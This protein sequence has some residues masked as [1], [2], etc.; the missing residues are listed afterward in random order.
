MWLSGQAS[1]H[2]KH[3]AS[4]F[5]CQ[6]NLVWHKISTQKRC[7]KKWC[8]R[9]PWRFVGARI[10][11][12]CFFVLL[13]SIF[14]AE[15]VDWTG[16]QPSFSS[17]LGYLWRWHPTQR[18]S[19]CLQRMLRSTRTNR[20]WTVFSASELW[21][22]QVRSCLT[23]YHMAVLVPGSCDLPLAK[24]SWTTICWAS[25]APTKGTRGKQR[26]EYTHR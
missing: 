17:E 18:R 11:R 26:F 16:P 20:F 21:N 2:L 22:C 1:G 10:A 9:M 15:I 23:Q 12:R 3:A 8:T 14:L 19:S 4:C 24:K 5:D 7:G 6:N 13:N 25:K